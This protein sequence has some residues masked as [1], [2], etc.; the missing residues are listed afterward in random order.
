MGRGRTR[1][2]GNRGHAGV[3]VRSPALIS[4]PG[5]PPMR[6]TAMA[7]AVAAVDVVHDMGAHCRGRG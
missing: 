4:P 6:A 3:R 1:S 2:G 5:W 7:I